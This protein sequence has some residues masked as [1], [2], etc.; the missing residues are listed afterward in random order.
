MLVIVPM[1][2]LIDPSSCLP[3]LPF[4]VGVTTILTQ[5][6]NLNNQARA[7]ELELASKSKK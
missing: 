6:D 4:L 1:G 5:G 3:P 7:K 2:K